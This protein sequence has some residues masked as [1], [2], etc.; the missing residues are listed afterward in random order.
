M[1]TADEASPVQGDVR[2]ISVTERLPEENTMCLTYTPTNRFETKY[3]VLRLYV[4]ESGMRFPGKVTHW[5]QIDPPT[6]K[7]SRDE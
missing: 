4:Y 2:W 1:S 3:R 7:V 5:Q 6:S